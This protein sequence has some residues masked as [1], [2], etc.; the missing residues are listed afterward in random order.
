MFG[1]KNTMTCFMLLYVEMEYVSEQ[2]H[3]YYSNKRERMNKPLHSNYLRD[4]IV[5]QVQNILL[6]IV[7]YYGNLIQLLL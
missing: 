1:I 2:E 3:I 5:V 7:I 6:L 4:R